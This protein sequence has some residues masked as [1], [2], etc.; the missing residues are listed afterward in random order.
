MLVRWLHMMY[1]VHAL[2]VGCPERILLI[3]VSRP[4]DKNFF[5]I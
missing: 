3:D 2:N 1:D 5:R 4:S